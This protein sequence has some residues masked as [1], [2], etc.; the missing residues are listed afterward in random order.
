MQVVCSCGPIR[1]RKKPKAQSV[2]N[3][4]QITRKMS[5]IQLSEGQDFV[6]DWKP[7]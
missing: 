5:P 2:K 7:Q 3:R 4:D 1:Y 6:D